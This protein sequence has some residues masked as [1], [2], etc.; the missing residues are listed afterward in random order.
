MKSKNSTI[1]RPPLS[2]RLLF[3]MSLAIPFPRSKSQGKL[4]VVRPPLYCLHIP[5]KLLPLPGNILQSFDSRIPI[6]QRTPRT[7]SYC[8][9]PPSPTIRHCT[10]NIP[11]TTERK[12]F[13]Q[14]PQLLYLT[15]IPIVTSFV[16]THLQ[17][18][19]G[20][21]ENFRQTFTLQKSKRLGRALTT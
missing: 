15:L 3:T 12:I 18:G 6:E 17:L 4:T 14:F 9:T 2:P 21:S 1:I 16:S 13:K 11:T 10:I 7:P 8:S 19:F 5:S 20:L